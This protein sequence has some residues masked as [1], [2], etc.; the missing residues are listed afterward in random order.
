MY[1]RILPLPYLNHIPVT[2]SWG[3]LSHSSALTVRQ[4]ASQITQTLIGDNS[5]AS[6]SQSPALLL[7]IFIWAP[8]SL[9]FLFVHGLLSLTP[10]PVLLIIKWGS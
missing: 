6:L 4:F 7:C 2:Q 9:A 1:Q 3:T 10:H 5:P 8:P